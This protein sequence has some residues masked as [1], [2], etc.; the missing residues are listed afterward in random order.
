MAFLPLA[1][2]ACAAPDE[3]PPEQ[4]DTVVEP[5]EVAWLG[6][7]TLVAPPRVTDDPVWCWTLA[8]GE[9]IA[10]GLPTG[11]RYRLPLLDPE[12]DTGDFWIDDFTV[13]DDALLWS[14]N[15]GIHRLSL[16]TVTREDVPFAYARGIGVWNGQASVATLLEPRGLT[17]YDSWSAVEE[18]S[19]LTLLWS[20]LDD[21]A[22]FS[23]LD[24]HGDDA[25]GAWHSTDEIERF[26]PVSGQVRERIPLEGYSGWIWGLDVEGGFLQIVGA[27]SDDSS[28]RSVHQFDLQGRWVASVEIPDGPDGPPTRPYGLWCDSL[29]DDGD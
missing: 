12:S 27:T 18:R 5:P 1:L 16:A 29:D 2:F 10:I 21:T 15:D 19:G 17:V 14:D 23:R 8:N 9:L 4:E 20:F 11:R 6:R 28:R 25:F 22:H 7:G 13:L 24:I 3:V 26:D